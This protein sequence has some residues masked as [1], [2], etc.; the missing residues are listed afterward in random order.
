M[1][2][3]LLY[4]AFKKIKEKKMLNVCKFEML[5]GAD[6]N[7]FGNSALAFCRAAKAI[8][9]VNSANYYWV[10]PNLIGFIIDFEDGSWGPG[11]EANA[12]VMKANFA[13]SDLS[14]MVSNEFWATARSG[15]DSYNLA[16]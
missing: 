8:Q 12:Q 10:N 11:A 7:S 1:T 9:G 13:L 4:K 5:S 2:Y 3:G 16:Q 15:T 6:R 14:S